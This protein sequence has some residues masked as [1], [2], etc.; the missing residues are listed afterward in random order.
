MAAGALI[1][2]QM[3]VARVQPQACCHEADHAQDLAVRLHPVYH[4]AVRSATL[5][6]RMLGIQ[7]SGQAP[8]LL[9]RLGR[10][11]LKRTAPR[12]SIAYS[13]SSAVKLFRAA[14]AS[15]GYG[16]DR[17]PQISGQARQGLA[18]GGQARLAARIAPVVPLAQPAGHPP[19]AHARVRRGI[20]RCATTRPWMASACGARRALLQFY[21]TYYLCVKCAVA[22]VSSLCPS[23]GLVPTPADKC[24]YRRY[25]V[26]AVS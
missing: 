12:A 9:A 10:A 13:S 19:S 3:L 6:Q 22:L 4:P 2:P 21:R 16:S 25:V 15:V 17:Q 11:W 1:Q 26:E 5:L 7:Q 14:A 20:V 18:R 24:Y 8:P 23:A